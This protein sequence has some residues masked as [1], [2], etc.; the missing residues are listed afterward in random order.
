MH[1][2]PVLVATWLAATV[3]WVEALTIVLA[4]SLTIGWK[5]TLGASATALLVLA[6]LTFVTGGVLQTWHELSVLRGL[7]GVFLLLFGVRWLAK[8]IARNAGLKALHDEEKIFGQTRQALQKES[9][10]AAWLVAFKGVLL[11]GLEVWLIV[12]T[13][14]SQMHHVGY[15]AA[16]ALLAFVMVAALGLA[17]HKPLRRV[18]ENTIKY[19]V[20]VMI[21][22]FGTF[23]T[24]ESLGYNWEGGDVALIGLFAVYCIG[25]WA[26][27]AILKK[28]HALKESAV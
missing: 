23:W 7:I 2:I 19:F 20:G 8:A 12:V 21:T 28:R 6:A 26:A 5:P 13:L 9:R 11:E 4:V 18:P 1:L 25:G 3:E 24:L 27:S 14:G 22:S 10:K 17:I 15:A 16:V